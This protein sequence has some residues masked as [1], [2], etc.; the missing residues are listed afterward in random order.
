VR[1]V[2]IIIAA[3]IVTASCGAGTPTTTTISPPAVVPV[4][5]STT[6]TTT[7]LPDDED[8]TRPAP[9][10]SPPLAAGV[11]SNVLGDQW[12]AADN[13]A[14]CSALFPEAPDSLADG[15]DIRSAIFTGGWAVAWDLGSGPGR[16][17]SGEYCEDCGRGA[18][19]VAGSG[20]RASGDET[21]TWPDSVGWADGS[22]GGFGYE[23]D[24]PAGSGAPV[25]MHLLIKDQ[26]CVYNVWSF[27]GETHLREL[28]DQLRFIQ[29]LQGDPTLWLNELPPTPIVDLGDAPWTLAA[30]PRSEL[31]EEAY[32]EWAGEAGAP[33]SCPVLFFADLGD[34]GDATIRRA[35]NEGEMLVAWDLPSGPGHDGAGSPCEDCG[36]GAIGLG[37]LQTGSR[38]RGLPVAYEWSDGSNAR[39]FSE[40]YSYGFE[41][42]LEITGFDCSYWMWSHLGV[43]HLEYLFSQLRRVEGLP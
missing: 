8:S 23:G 40:P 3:G 43:E 7:T 19:G 38:G 17:P 37:T 22:V 1:T 42:S 4:A 41:A 27:L 18:F 36:R 32:L 16:E 9:W 2:V 31:P 29:G 24:Q 25:V 15:A 5:T 11:V 34:A 12:N 35:A 20:R 14:W 6:T 33:E 13:R 30:L 21:S 26:G 28:V 39:V 10:S